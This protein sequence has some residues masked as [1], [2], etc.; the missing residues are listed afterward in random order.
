MYGTAR[1]KEKRDRY[2]EGRLGYEQVAAAGFAAWGFDARRIWGTPEYETVNIFGQ[3]VRFDA[4]DARASGVQT[5]VLTMP[6]VL[7]G[8]EFGWRYPGRGLAHQDAQVDFRKMADEVY[9][10]QE[11]RYAQAS[12][13]TARTDYQ[14]QEAP[15]LVYDAVYAAGY[16]WNTVG[17]DGK[18]YEKLALVSTRAAFGMWALWPSDYTDR[19]ME[20]VQ[21]LHNPDRGWYE[22]RLERSGA[23]Q[24]TITLSTNAGVLEALLFKVKG[25]LYP[26]E[27]TPG[28]FRLQQSDIFMRSS[29]CL[30]SERPICEAQAPKPAIPALQK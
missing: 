9:R 12:I 25:R 20:V 19:L 16:P 26:G 13:F 2:Q 21:Y 1:S 22:G 17:P 28:Y 5:P 23:M 6:H 29:Q 3:P 18:E 4:R 27:S 30:P 15:Y 14:I 10:A 11:T 24:E 8:M 7:M